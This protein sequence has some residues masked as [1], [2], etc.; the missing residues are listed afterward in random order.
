MYNNYNFGISANVGNWGRP[1]SVARDDI[2]SAKSVDPIAPPKMIYLA[3]SN[4]VYHRLA[5]PSNKHIDDILQETGGKMTRV[6]ANVSADVS[7]RPKGNPEPEKDKVKLSLGIEVKGRFQ[8]GKVYR[9]ETARE[10]AL[11]SCIKK[12]KVEDQKID[13]DKPIVL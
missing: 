1:S 12:Y 7:V 6:I 3:D 9:I 5:I 10:E 2:P 4:H 8:F 13:A 11:E